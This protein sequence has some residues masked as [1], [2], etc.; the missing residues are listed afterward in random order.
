M[1]S[2][3]DETVVLSNGED[4]LLDYGVWNRSY[5]QTTSVDWKYNDKYMSSGPILQLKNESQ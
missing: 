4:R 2:H 1:N 3:V 5:P